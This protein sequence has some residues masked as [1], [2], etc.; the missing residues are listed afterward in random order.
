[1]NPPL[2]YRTKGCFWDILRDSGISRTM[3]LDLEFSF[4]VL[5]GGNGFT[6]DVTQTADLFD[7][8][9]NIEQHCNIALLR[10][11]KYWVSFQIGVQNYALRSKSCA[12]GAQESIKRLHEHKN[13]DM[14]WIGGRGWL[15][16]YTL[17]L[18]RE[19]GKR[20]VTW[21]SRQ[22]PLDMVQI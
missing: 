17:S 3:Y 14:A 21:L 13:I 9:S 19:L 1:M 16:N 15:C 12:L 20:R 10:M 6:K 7:R 18:L 2:K 22:I 11:M 5:F 4:F 8:L